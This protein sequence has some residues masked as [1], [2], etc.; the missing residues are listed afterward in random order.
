MFVFQIL[1]DMNDTM[2]PPL[3]DEHPATLQRFLS[4]KDLARV[5]GVSESS[6]KRWVD[7]GR[8]KAVRTAGGHRRIAAKEALSFLRRE[9][10]PIKDPRPLGM[11]PAP[12][13]DRSLDDQLHDLLKQGDLSRAR[14]LLVQA[15]HGGMRLAELA[16]GPIRSSLERIGTLWTHGQD[17]IATEHLATDT[18]LQAV[19]TIRLMLPE[20]APTAPLAIG[21][22]PSKDPYLLPSLCCASA[23]QEI[24]FEAQNLGPDTPL[25][26]IVGLAAKRQPRLIWLAVSCEEAALALKAPLK[27]HLEALTANGTH[28]IIGGRNAHLLG[29]DGRPRL[30]Q[31]R[32]LGEVAAF[33]RGLL[34]A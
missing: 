28:L 19:L 16:D 2:S 21:G 7:E 26:V 27:R 15:Y 13:T 20:P 12:V 18:I 5:I 29:V 30:V 3:I 33:A 11:A 23:L 8:L 4:P 34:G 32:S 14:S 25:D 10:Y 9:G 22:A 24:G 6:L 1:D 31:S 17:G